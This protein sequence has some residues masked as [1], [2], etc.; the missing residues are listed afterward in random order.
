MA[1]QAKELGI[2]SRLQLAFNELGVTKGVPQPEFVAPKGNNDPPRYVHL[3]NLAWQYFCATIL[4]SAADKRK[5][6]AKK[7]CESVGM[8][9][10]GKDIKPGSSGIIHETPDLTI[11]CEKKTPATRI[12]PVALKNELSILLGGDETKIAKVLAR[13]TKENAPATSYKVLWKE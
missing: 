3:H 5:D 2:E 7:S 6:I 1:T 4:A 13:V 12:D 8:W 10:P 9:E 11:L